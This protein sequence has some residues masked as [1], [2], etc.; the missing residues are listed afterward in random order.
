MSSLTF[1]RDF[2]FGTATSAY[3]IEGAWNEDGKGPSIW[4]AFVRKRGA[5]A[6]GTT[7]D[8]AADHYHRFRED[9]GIMR[10]LGCGSYRFSISWPRVFPEGHGNVCVKGVDFYDALV[11]ALRESGIEPFVTLYH[12]DMPERLQREGGWYRRA[13]TDRFAE[14]TETV[15]KRL[16]DRVSFWMPINEPFAIMAE[17]H[18]LGTAAPGKKNLLK[19]HLVGHNLLLAHGKSLQRIKSLR[20]AAQVGIVNA[21]WPNDPFG[22]GDG[23]AARYAND[24]FI[25][26]FMDPIYKKRYP[27]SLER[28]VSILNREIRPGDFDIIGQPVDFVG[29]NYYSRNVVK[30]S[31]NP[32]QRFSIVDSRGRGVPVTA[33][34]LEIYPEGM[35]RILRLLRQEYNDPVIYITENGAAFDDEVR[36]GRVDDERR[37]EY[38]RSYL[39]E[40]HRAMQEGV[41]VK[42]HFVWS[43]MDNFEW[44]DGLSRRLGLVH[45]D[46]RTQKRTVKKSGYWYGELCRSG[47]LAVDDGAP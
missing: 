39:V 4:D 27:R 13:T 16:G 18:A 5:I 6:D 32:V 7:G 2:L 19:A 25:G 36:D 17:G 37:I 15:V 46:F 8:V 23:K 35:G 24:Y 9:V 3:Q 26:F 47:K 22:P 11:D 29:V 1:P 41:R 38:L 20:P 21:L 14:F 31:L 42:G 33:M 12:W 43:L 45:V 28:M 34:G 40:V 44:A 30:R 10:A